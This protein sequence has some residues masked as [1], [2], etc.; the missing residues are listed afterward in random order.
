MIAIKWKPIISMEKVTK[1]SGFTIKKKKK[2]R[3]NKDH[4]GS[5]DR[6]KNKRSNGKG[7]QE[8]DGPASSLDGG[9]GSGISSSGTPIGASG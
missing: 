8:L 1:L 3:K 4:A 6:N 5:I 7:V 2:R 9:W